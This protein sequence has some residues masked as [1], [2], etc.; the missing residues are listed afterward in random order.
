MSM[1]ETSGDEAVLNEMSRGKKWGNST[2]N[3]NHKHS[4]FSNNCKVTTTNTN[5]TDFKK[6]AKSNSGHKGQKTAKITLTQESDHYIPTE[7]SGNF[8]K[9]FDLAMKLK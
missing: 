7:L 6:I 8:F 2:N 9:E 1:K 5:R 4:N 3:Y